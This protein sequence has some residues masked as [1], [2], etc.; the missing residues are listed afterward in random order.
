M[1]FALLRWLQFFNGAARFRA[2]RSCPRTRATSTPTSSMGPRA[3]ARGDRRT[4]LVERK[5]THSSMGPRAFARGDKASLRRLISAGQSSMGPRAFARGD[6]THALFRSGAAPLQWG[7]ALS[8]AEIA[9]ID[10]IKAAAGPL[11]WGRALSRAE[12]ALAGRTAQGGGC[13]SMGPRAFARG[14]A[15][16]EYCSIRGR[17][18]GAFRAGQSLGRPVAGTAT[19]ITGNVR[20]IRVEWSCGLARLSGRSKRP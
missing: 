8:R 6:L 11:Q 2:R 14:D 12:I 19:T 17:F 18:S 10:P 5:H 4:V 16:G 9:V 20:H 3:F 7:R 13:S 1:I 15:V